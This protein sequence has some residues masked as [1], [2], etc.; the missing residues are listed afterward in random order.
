[1]Q[2]SE[3]IARFETATADQQRELLSE[4][5]LAINGPSPGLWND[6][7]SEWIERKAIFDTLLDAEAYESAALTLVPADWH[8]SLNGVNDSWHATINDTRFGKAGF[9]TGYA[10][11]PALAIVIARLRA[12][13]EGE[14]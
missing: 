11:T 3:L 8:L 2:T 13:N 6:G 1:M 12:R 7:F 14:A 9:E 10:P 4:A 5:W